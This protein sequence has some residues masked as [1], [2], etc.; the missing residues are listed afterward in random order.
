M[1]I[2]SVL[3]PIFKHQEQNDFNPMLAKML[4]IAHVVL[5]S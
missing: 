1:V 4:T 2:V 3:L 5:F